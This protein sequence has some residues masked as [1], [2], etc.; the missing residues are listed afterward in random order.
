MKERGQEGQVE[1]IIVT[2]DIISMEGQGVFDNSYVKFL[3][4]FSLGSITTVKT[5][6]ENRIVDMRETKHD[7]QQIKTLKEWMVL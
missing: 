4:C 7:I 5:Q 2:G 3:T 6:V 1:A